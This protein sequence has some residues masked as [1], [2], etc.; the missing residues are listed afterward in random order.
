MGSLIPLHIHL[1]HTRLVYFWGVFLLHP[2]LKENL[3]D[4]TVYMCLFLGGKISL[5]EE[6]VL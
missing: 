2:L 3:E 6:K 1:K 5:K 4:Y